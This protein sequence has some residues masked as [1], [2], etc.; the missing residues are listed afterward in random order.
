MVEIMT[1][2]QELILLGVLV[3]KNQQE[4][5][6]VNE[7]LGEKI[8]WIEVAGQLMNHRLCGYFYY[9]LQKCNCDTI[10]GEIYKALKLMVQA[11]KT[12]MQEKIDDVLPI[13]EE[14]EKTDIRYA[15]LKGITLFASYYEMGTRRSNDIDL[16]VFEEDLDKFDKV[17]RSLGFVQ[18]NPHGEE[19]IEASKKDK[20]IQRMNYHDLIPYLK[21]TS[22][23]ICNIDVNFLFDNNKNII[24]DKVF[25]MGTTLYSGNGYRVR[26][27]NTYTN[28]AHLCAHFHR[29]ATNIIWTQ[30]EADMILYK[31]VDIINYVRHF[32]NQLELETWVSV[33]E[34]L[35][36]KEPVYYTF[37]VLQQFYDN[38]FVSE[39]EKILRPEDTTFLKQITVNG[40][41][42]LE[43]VEGFVET[44]FR[45]SK[46][47]G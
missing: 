23:G 17:M 33:V 28:L 43:R 16:L 15:G 26:G 29:E 5:D 39:C 6:R 24:E 45:N 20:L 46:N 18:S 27:L 2:E 30:A 14:L 31:L 36:L 25:K 7:L 21:K 9:G 11:M 32:A 1:K 13:L 44:A 12:D 4:I 22:H 34:E 3:E 42:K 35:N 41:N 8:N 37:Y 47:E 40:D 38:S 10:P 19:I